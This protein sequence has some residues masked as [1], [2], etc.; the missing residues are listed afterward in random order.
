[1]KLYEIFQQYDAYS[2]ARLLM[3]SYLWDQSS[4]VDTG[5][6]VLIVSLASLLNSSILYSLYYIGK[7]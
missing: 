1:V 3:V 5:N 7:K 2:L 6:T 4:R